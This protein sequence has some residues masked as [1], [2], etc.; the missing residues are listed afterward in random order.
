LKIFCGASWD[1]T[2]ISGFSVQRVDQLCQDSVIV[3]G[4]FITTCTRTTKTV[5]INFAKETSSFCWL[6]VRITNLLCRRKYSKLQA[7]VLQTRPLPGSSAFGVQ[8]GTRTPKPVMALAPQASVS[9][10]STIW[11]Y[12]VRDSNP[13]I[14]TN[15]I[16]GLTTLTAC[17]TQRLFFSSSKFVP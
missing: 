11:T 5:S 3:F 12:C 7:G 14:I 1:R 9:T 8:R 6:G 4:H 13:R 2:W 16:E 10:N 17:I 15:Q